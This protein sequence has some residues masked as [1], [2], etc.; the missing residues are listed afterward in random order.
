MIG[1]LLTSSL[2]SINA[3]EIKNDFSKE[4]EFNI[5]Y[6]RESFDGYTLFN[7]YLSRNT[8]LINNTDKKVVHEWKS[9]HRLSLGTYLSENKNLIRTSAIYNNL[10]LWKGGCGGRVEIFDWD[11][12]LVWDF[13]YIGDNYCLHNDIEVLPNGNI[14]MTVWESKTRDEVN[15]SGGDLNKHG[16][17]KGE[18]LLI[19]YLIEVEPTGPTSGDIV[20]EWHIWDHLIQDYD[21]TKDNY[22]VVA[23]HPELLDINFHVGG[24]G[25]ITHIN[26]IYYNETYD[27]LL[28]SSRVASEIWVI[29]HST[30]TAEAA[31]HTGGNSGKGGDILYRW[32]NPQNYHM[33]DEND[34]KLFGQH[35]ARWIEQGCPGEGHITIFNNGYLRPDGNYS[36]VEEIIPPMSMDENGNYYLESGS[37]YGPEESVWTYTAENPTDFYSCFMSGAQRLPNGNTFIC[38]GDDGYFFEVNSEKEIL[39]NYLNP[40]PIYIP[41]YSFWILEHFNL[42]FKTQC[43]TKD[44]PGIGELSTNIESGTF[45]SEVTVNEVGSSTQT[46]QSSPSSSPTNS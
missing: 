15:D 44:Y 36:S 4:L 9:D 43:Y 13:T 46:L 29:D 27:Q 33:G 31:G 6:T 2:V 10:F 30:N 5:S 42:L 3:L 40:Y 17:F 22:G 35:D 23:D 39:W 32:G 38:N 16:F 37:A 8:Y 26:S 19:D 1:L 25:D 14:L 41:F 34:Q 11:G 24:Y 28:L 21:P 20:W 18:Y 7:P 12:N 45:E